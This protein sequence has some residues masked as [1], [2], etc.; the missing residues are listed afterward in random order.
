MRPWQ[1]CSLNGISRET[2][3]FQL[4]ETPFYG[5]PLM[6]RTPL[7]NLYN[8]FE[9]NSYIF[10][11]T[12]HTKY[13]HWLSC[14]PSYK[15]SYTVKPAAFRPLVI[16]ARIIYNFPDLGQMY[17]LQLREGAVAKWR[18]LREFVVGFRLAPRVFLCVFRYSSLHNTRPNWNYPKFFLNGPS[19]ASHNF[20]REFDYYILFGHVKAKEITLKLSKMKGHTFRNTIIFLNLSSPHVSR[21]NFYMKTILKWEWCVLFR[22]F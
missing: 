11:K 10:S 2:A 18:C 6:R 8:K 19:R 13:E 1:L 17:I 21:S 7:Y 22:K 4:Q 9:L 20:I 16:C 15:L 3:T 14:V 5:Y 12:K